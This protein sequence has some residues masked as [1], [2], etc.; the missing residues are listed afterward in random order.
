[1][2]EA[3]TLQAPKSGRSRFSKAL[4]APPSLPAFDFESQLRPVPEKALPPQQRSPPEGSLPP[5]PPPKK[6]ESERDREPTM[7]TVTR[8]LNSPLPPL[9]APSKSPGPPPPMSIPRRPVAAPSATPTKAAAPGPAPVL[10]PAPTLAT[11]QP[12]PSPV[13]SIS[14]LLS[15]YS[16]HTAESTPQSPANSAQDTTSSN[17]AYSVVGPNLGI[18]SSSTK[19]EA[20]AQAL[21]TLSSDRSAQ[22]HEANNPQTI[23]ADRDELFLQLPPP[24]P[25]SKDAQR[26]PPRPQTPTGPQSQTTQLPTSPRIA[27]SPGNTSPQ[28]Q[29]WRRRSLKADK[30]VSVPDLKLVASHGSTAASAQNSSQSG[31]SDAP[32]QPILPSAAEPKA[33]EP[34]TAT[35]APPPQ[36]ANAG[37][38]GRNIRP[39]APGESVSQGETSMGQEASCIKD[40]IKKKVLE[41][42]RRHESKEQPEANEPEVRTSHAAA[43]PSPTAPLPSVSPLSAQRLPT[44]EYGTND[45]KSPPLDIVV[46][47]VSPASTPELAGG[48]KPNIAHG[49]AR[50]PEAQIRHAKSTPSLTARTGNA[51]AGV[52]R[53]K[54]LPA[55]P[56]PDRDRGL[57]QTRSP[58]RNSNDQRPF[59]AATRQEPPASTDSQGTYQR[60]PRSPS[61]SWELKSISEAGSIDT[62]KPTLQRPNHI[63]PADDPPL[64]EHDPDQ[65]DKTDNPGAARF[66]RNWYT[67]F[68]ADHILDARPLTDRHFRCLTQHRYVTANRQRTNPI[69][70][71]TCG[72]KDRNAECYICSACHLNVCS[73][74]SGL[75]RRFRGDL[76]QVL[77]QIEEKRASQTTEK[78]PPSAD[79]SA[80]AAI[81]EA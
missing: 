43:T 58:S 5:L 79:E 60:D 32:P 7:A 33:A 65:P 23:R 4:P 44:P 8:P 63:A 71:R 37:L 35:R 56:A 81:L 18:Q 2:M 24:P 74:C 20:R 45:V 28:E 70:C 66:P 42:H 47:P 61:S 48:P 77:Q 34:A 27:S 46:S 16:N 1:M 13:G 26:G 22:R 64:R 29:L 39:V 17:T 55:F 49:T 69:A 50:A 15:A 73:G 57:N 12:E 3:A 25:P 78:P 6:P 36:T 75:L 67:P 52:R 54:G 31:P 68:P 51:E 62:V 53:G 30:N 14:S 40:K 21:P 72:H 59:A 38:P 9:P 11:P 19:D 10:I 41:V 76:S 80:T